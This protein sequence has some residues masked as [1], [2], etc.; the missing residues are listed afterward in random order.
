MREL[1]GYSPLW[2][3]PL[4]VINL[5]R[6]QDRLNTFDAAAARA[7]WFPSRCRIPAV[8]GAALPASMSPQLISDGR[9]AAAVHRTRQHI[10]TPKGVNLTMGSVG[11]Y[12]SHAL[13]W[14][15]IVDR[16]L[17]AALIAEDDIV[18]YSPDFM[19]HLRRLPPPNDSWDY[20][21]LQSCHRGKRDLEGVGSSVNTKSR[22][23]NASA[24][25]MGLYVM[26]NRCISSQPPSHPAPL[27]L[28]PLKTQRGLLYMCVC[29]VAV[30]LGELCRLSSR[31]GRK[32]SWMGEGS[33]CDQN[34]VDL[35][36]TR[37]SLNRQV[38]CKTPT[39][40]F[41]PGAPSPR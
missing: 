21:Q 24:C 26:S 13:A 39:H 15:H 7:N 2:S 36:S 4:L 1:D 25:C 33:L 18:H 14:R 35:D 8:D 19:A 17:T 3:P 22:L 32:V 10:S 12:F 11:L 29:C 20:I 40:R 5:A 37:L 28:V 16:G 30:V 31:F 41:S 23:L 9:Y 34:A 27:R 38:I 6:R